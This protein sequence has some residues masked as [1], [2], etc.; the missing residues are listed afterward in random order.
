M[1]NE[2]HL[3]ANVGSIETAP[4]VFENV[5]TSYIAN[6]TTIDLTQLPFDCNDDTQ[7]IEVG[8][9]FYVGTASGN[10]TATVTAYDPNTCTIT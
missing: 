9:T 4:V 3:I 2:V 7:S 5:N 10:Q 8:A 6:L 1:M